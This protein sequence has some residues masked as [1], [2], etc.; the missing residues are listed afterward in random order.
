MLTKYAELAAQIAALVIDKS[1]TRAETGKRIN[2]QKLK[3][4]TGHYLKED[5]DTLQIVLVDDQLIVKSPNKNDR[6]LTYLG[7]SNFRIHDSLDNRIIFG[8]KEDEY[9]VWK[10]RREMGSIA[11]KIEVN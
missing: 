8:T 9:L 2:S 7:N 6:P 3:K 5:G 4:F 11:R 10:P 1:Y